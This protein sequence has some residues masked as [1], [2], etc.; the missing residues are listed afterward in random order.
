MKRINNYYI[1]Q[2]TGEQEVI[3]GSVQRLIGLKDDL[4]YEFRVIYNSI[5]LFSFMT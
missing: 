2:L 1:K 3:I 4:T 5:K